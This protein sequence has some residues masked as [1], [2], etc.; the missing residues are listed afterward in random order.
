[1]SKGPATQR[2]QWLRTVGRIV[3]SG[4][5]AN[6]SRLAVYRNALRPGRAGLP[7]GMGLLLG[8]IAT[9]LGVVI[10]L[11]CLALWTEYLNLKV[12]YGNTR[13]VEL[14]AGPAWRSFFE[15]SDALFSALG[16][17][18]QMA[19]QTGGMTWSIRL[20]GVP[21]TDPVALLSL[22]PAD[23]TPAAGFALGAIIP[24]GIAVTLGRVFCGYVCPASLLFFAIGRLRRRLG[25]LLLFPELSLG[26]GFAWGVLVA[27]IALTAAI[28]HGVWTLLLPYFAMGQTIFHGIAFG[29]LS[30]SM[31]ALAVFALLDL[32]AGYQF[33]C[34]NLCPTGRLLGALGSRAPIS[35][36][37]DPTR[38]VHHC[39]ACEEVCP[40]AVS[41][42]LDETRDCSMCGACLVICPSRCL[43]VGTV[44]AG[45][46][47]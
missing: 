3:D 36:R 1:M 8:S 9:R 10:L 4:S 46:A 19:E 24:M 47:M 11:C 13:L 29:T 45:G 35:V 37:R 28:G 23:P 44:G 21:F 30:A 42:R 33:T 31:V 32:L 15:A 26:R 20:L 12:G 17:P 2:R 25:G 18:V 16:D 41:P 7:P 14:A 22:L 39:H 38:C 6:A 40:F 27:G 43:R 5:M 34:R